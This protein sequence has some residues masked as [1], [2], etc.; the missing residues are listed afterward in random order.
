MRQAL[1]ALCLAAAALT[2]SPA[3][4]QE[5]ELTTFAWLAGTWQATEG[6]RVVEEQWMTPTVDRMIGMSR[7]VGG[8]RT[9][10]YEFLRIEKRGNDLFYIPQ[11]NG[12]PPV[13]FTLASSD[14]GRF[15]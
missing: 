4:A 13:S 15:V 6:A 1:T 8:G 9:L 5:R 11:P 3:F 14:G 12:R 10:E 7:T 2:V